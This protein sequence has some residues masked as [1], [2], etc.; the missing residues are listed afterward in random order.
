[1]ADDRVLIV[2]V[3]SFELSQG[4]VEVEVA[5][6]VVE[7]LGGVDVS[8]CCPAAHVV[9]GDREPE[10]EGAV[11]GGGAL[12][13]APEPFC[14][15]DH[16]AGGLAQRGVGGGETGQA[17]GDQPL[18][19]P[20]G[21]GGDDAR[22]G[23]IWPGPAGAGGL[24]GQTRV[25]ASPADLGVQGGASGVVEPP[26]GLRGVARHRRPHPVGVGGVQGDRRGKLR[27]G[28]GRDR[29][30]ARPGPAAEPE[31]G[32]GVMSSSVRTRSSCPGSGGVRAGS[33]GG[34]RLRQTV[35]SG[36]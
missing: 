8:G 5:V 9:D 14:E 13:E 33:G 4:G 11:V 35:M 1:V 21:A 31:M 24:R 12:V 26:R 7:V 28:H 3:E 19:R 32:H 34:A 25:S 30:N 6:V 23:E 27:C 20:V 15:S 29:S 10:L 16:A 18:E 2:G 17:G 36:A 22:D